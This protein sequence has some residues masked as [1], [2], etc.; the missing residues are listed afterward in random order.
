MD[1]SSLSNTYINNITVFHYIGQIY[2][3][4][5]IRGFPFTN[6]YLLSICTFSSF[7]TDWSLPRL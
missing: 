6:A 3:V 2:P 1:S 4:F 7:G 5:L